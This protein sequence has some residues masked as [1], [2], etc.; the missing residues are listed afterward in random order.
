M[1]FF[2]PFS[3]KIFLDI[4]YNLIN[5]FII[6]FMQRQPFLRSE[7]VILKVSLWEAEDDK[8]LTLKSETCSSFL[9]PIKIFI[10][11]RHTFS[12]RWTSS[13]AEGEKS[14]R[15]VSFFLPFVMWREDAKLN[16]W[17]CW[18]SENKRCFV[19]HIPW[20][21]L[22]FSSTM[23]RAFFLQNLIIKQSF[24][25]LMVLTFLSS[26]ELLSCRCRRVKLRVYAKVFL[27]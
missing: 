7:K 20:Y 6:I 10:T 22:T 14:A 21:L 19:L 18:G 17:K 25:S 12:S 9:Y 3:I 5:S 15:H 8:T 26:S 24:L 11:L 2:L 27:V 1:T 4:F 13:G 23:K 16:V